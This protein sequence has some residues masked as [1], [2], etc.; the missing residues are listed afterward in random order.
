M[1]IGIIGSRR[2][3]SVDDR[4][5]LH[6]KVSQLIFS[7]FGNTLDHFVKCGVLLGESLDEISEY[8][9]RIYR[10]VK[11]I[12]GD[13]NKGGDEFARGLCKIYPFKLD[14]KKIRD[15]MTGEE[16][17]FDDHA[18]FDYYT[19]CNI[20]Y[21]RNKEIAK[22]NL[23]YLIALVAPDR[24]GGTEKTI[25]FFKKYHKDWEKKLIIL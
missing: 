5:V 11:I 17:D 23:D 2:R 16:L 4:D 25:E 20:Y 9:D 15:P 19:M 22:E 12:T 7:Y 1:I 6:L 8:Y 3:T 21:D 24:T 18:Y 10:Q 13:C 14:V